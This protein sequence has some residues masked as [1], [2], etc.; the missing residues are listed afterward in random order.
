MHLSIYWC[1]GKYF[2]CIV[3]FGGRIGELNKDGSTPWIAED[4]ICNSKMSRSDLPTVKQYEEYDAEHRIRELQNAGCRNQH[5]RT[6]GDQGRRQMHRRGTCHVKGS[7]SKQATPS[8]LSWGVKKWKRQC[9]T[10]DSQCALLPS[11][12][13]HVPCQRLDPRKRRCGAIFLGKE[14]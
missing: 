10:W 3:K 8:R 7:N 12:C 2:F 6:A 9:G 11:F 1:D 5:R 14:T 4:A 13:R